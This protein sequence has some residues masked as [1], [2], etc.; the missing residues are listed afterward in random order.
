MSQPHLQ[1]SRRLFVVWTVA[2]SL[3]GLLT[4]TWQARAQAQDQELRGPVPPAPY[5]STITPTIDP[6]VT[7]SPTPTPTQTPS[8][9]PTPSP[10]PTATVPPTVTPTPS[11]T[12]PYLPGSLTVALAANVP[13]TYVSPVFGTLTQVRSVSTGSWLKRPLHVLSE[14]EGASAQVKMMPLTDMADS[15]FA[16]LTEKYYAVV[17]PFDTVQDDISLRELELRWQGIESA[18]LF[19]TQEAADDLASVL[20]VQRVPALS[21]QSWHT[22][23]ANTSQPLGILP[24]EQLDPSFKVLTIDGVNVL[25]NNLVAT[26]YPLAVG[27]SVAG[28]GASI[29]AEKLRPVIGTQT[30]RDPNRLTT[31]VMTGVTAMTRGTARRMELYG[32]DY[33]ARV[34]SGTLAAADIT[35]ISNEVPFLDDCVVND[36]PNN[37]RMCSHTDYWA[38]LAAVGTDIVGLSGNHVNDFGRRGARRSI[39]WY[40]ENNIP[41]YGSGLNVTEACA[42]LLWEH[43]DNTFAFIAALAFGPDFAWATEE[44]PGACYYYD[45]KEELL[46]SIR[47]L[48]EI[49]D[50]V[51]VELQF[52]ESYNPYPLSYQVREFREIRAAGAELM[53]G[54]QSHVPQAWEPYGINDE[55]G[56]A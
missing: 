36:T 37:L 30:N 23:F 29:V 44:L 33:P 15:D 1:P 10:T 26:D 2:L 53:T 9:M 17:V 48:T 38:T 16:P 4:A 43:N 18:P 34:I 12:S 45:Q 32:D 52:E 51:A 42:P 47:N 8:P 6:N 50:V 46:A 31:L 24:F 41:I 56:R 28:T 39:G 20:G 14:V 54:V 35:H 55:V 25:D 3:I 7:P 49:V 19:F 22:L 27:L 5:F 11:P 40:R 13:D 21:T